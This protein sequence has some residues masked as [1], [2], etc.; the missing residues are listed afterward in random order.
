M[1]LHSIHQS[2]LKFLQLA[3]PQIKIRF[4]GYEHQTTLADLHMASNQ[5][6][7]KNLE[8]FALLTSTI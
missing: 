2:M 7:S 4:Y 6:T 3:D 8:A 1:K 5:A